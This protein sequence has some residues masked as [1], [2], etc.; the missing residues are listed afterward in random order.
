MGGDVVTMDGTTA[1]VMWGLLMVL[2]VAFFSLLGWVIWR[3]D[4]TH[5]NARGWERDAPGE[6]DDEPATSRKPDEG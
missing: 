1:A 3:N 5:G 4:R 2:L 6:T